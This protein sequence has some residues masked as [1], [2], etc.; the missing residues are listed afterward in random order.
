M[1]MDIGTGHFH[2]PLEMHSVH[3]APNES[4]ETLHFE[5]MLWEG[6]GHCPLHQNFL[7]FANIGLENFLRTL[8]CA[9]HWNCLPILHLKAHHPAGKVIALEVLSLID[10]VAKT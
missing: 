1:A 8:L 6:I 7:H 5:G 3:S 2:W 4:D 10:E 9:K